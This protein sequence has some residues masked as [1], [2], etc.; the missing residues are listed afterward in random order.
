MDE[1]LRSNQAASLPLC[2]RFDERE[3]SLFPEN[4]T[5][6]DF[7]EFDYADQSF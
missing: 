2:S 1:L 7:W 5:V 4:K 3:Y 6:V